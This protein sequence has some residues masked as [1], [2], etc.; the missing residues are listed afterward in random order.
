MTKEQIIEEVIQGI[1]NFKIIPFFGS[2]MSKPA[3]GK[4]WG[5]ITEEL[6]KELDT[7]ET[8]YLIVGQEYE[9]KYGRATLLTKLQSL[10]NLAKQTS[11]TLINHMRILVMNPP[12]IYTTNFDNAL[13]SAAKLIKRPYYTVTTLKDIVNMPHGIR[14]IIKFHG[15]FSEPESI[16]FTNGDYEKRLNIEN[17]PLDVLFRAHILGKS[18]L[19]LGYS[20]SDKNID[21]IFKLHVELYGPDSLNKSYI[22]S[23]NSDP[24]VEEKLKKKNVI[25]LV[26]ESPDE[27]T[28]LLNQIGEKITEKSIDRVFD[29]MNN[30]YVT[31]VIT[32]FEIND[33]KKI[34]EEGTLTNGELANKLRKAIELR[35]IPDD[36]ES[37]LTDF[38]EQILIG[39]YDKHIKIQIALAYQYIQFKKV[40]SIMKI[41][42][43]L[44]PLTS[45]PECRF[46]LVNPF[47]VEILLLIDMKLGNFFRADESRKTMTILILSYLE[48]MKTDNVALEFDH[49]DRLLSHLKDC[50]YKEFGDIAIGDYSINRI[51]YILNY[52][53]QKHGNTLKV[54]FEMPSFK[55]QRTVN[56][57]RNDIRNLI[58]GKN[59]M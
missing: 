9:N 25:T 6:K 58:P 40:E 19:F 43:A 59:F 53:F 57:I 49:V 24:V 28:A 35:E 18:I 50:R 22:I 34:F 14:Q 29:D 33:L 32:D 16:I 8:H 55:S 48:G 42:F 38:L 15:D 7:E 52:Y 46:N 51:N 26:L 20:F 41:A 12:I 2:G 44:I 31:T 47:E 11:A 36:L 27:L 30:S 39:D 56:E 10:C 21:H 17:S 4:D 54:R 45:L 3:G 1:L 5:E 13:E 37:S 23:F